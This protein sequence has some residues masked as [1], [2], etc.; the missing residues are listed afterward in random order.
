[1]LLP[2]RFQA[3]FALIFLVL[4]TLILLRAPASRRLDQSGLVL[5][6]LPDSI[7]L[8]KN[9]FRPLSH[10]PPE[11]QA[12][13]TA[14][15]THWY[16]DWKWRNPFSSAVTLDEDRA[17]LPP[18][19]LRPYI[20]TFYDSTIKKDETTEKAE[21]ELL[22]TWRR[23][24]WAQG[25]KPIVLGRPEAMNNQLYGELQ[26]LQVKPEL[27]EELARMLAWGHMGTGIL[28]DWLAYPM[29]HPDDSILSF[30]RRGE[31]TE[32]VA[33]EGLKGSLLCGEKAAVNQAIIDALKHP[34]IQTAKL[35]TEVLPDALKLEAKPDSIA[36][37]DPLLIA[38]MYTH[39]TNTLQSA[40]PD[41]H[42]ALL[43]E[44]VNSHLHATWQ[45]SFP[46]GI[47]I[48]QPL[49][50]DPTT[51]L[52]APL[53]DL[54]RTLTQCPRT[55]IPSSCPP[56]NP[57]CPPCVASRPLPLTLFPS[58]HNDSDAFTL[59]TV[60][61]PYTLTSLLHRAPGT[62]TTRL[63]RR[64]T[65]RNPWLSATTTHLLG[66]GP[67]AAVRTLLFK[68]LVASTS[69]S[70][71][72]ALWLTPEPFSAPSSGALINPA[73]AQARADLAWRLGFTLPDTHRDDGRRDPP[74][75]GAAMSTTNQHQHQQQRP[76]APQ[77]L[78]PQPGADEVRAEREVLARAAQVVVGGVA[79]EEEEGPGGGNGMGMMMMGRREV[80]AARRVSRAAE[81][82]HMADAE[83]W[84]FVRAWNA[85]G[86]VERAVWEE[87]ERRFVGGEERARGW[88]SWLGLG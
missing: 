6:K 69:T 64:S 80:E 85:R 22:L 11:E 23:A 66:H 25:F 37:Y 54:A 63:L 27:E 35:L 52:H 72:H 26:R 44:L 79:E 5:P 77:P 16:T 53:I 51:A 43:P 1:M 24:W 73:S 31:F 32:L 46:A 3:L 28:A 74:V 38:Q 30:L 10:K 56:N 39:I 50:K 60:P 29:A 55:P 33:F 70:A 4:V 68:D 71:R 45:S 82:W 81:A 34:N 41:F 57:K 19:P 21:H 17:V 58:Y 49:P 83:A 62:L 65:A 61:H 2:R 67:S 59:A 42:L 78:A 13:S 86:R 20:Y 88:G 84:R 8:P 12:N 36:L 48:H 15:E 75:P 7:S 18:Q 14:G 87:E 9:P 76:P 47:H 40:G